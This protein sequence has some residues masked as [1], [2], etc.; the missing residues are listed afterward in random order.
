[1]QETSFI[2]VLQKIGLNYREALVYFTLIKSGTRGSIVKEL[3]HALPGEMKRTTVYSTL[4]KL[5]NMGI[6]KESGHADTSKNATIFIGT[7]PSKYFKSLIMSKEKEIELIKKSMEKNMQNLEKIYSDGIELKFDD[8]DE[9]IKPY[10]KPLMDNGWKVK[11]FIMR[12]DVP[13]LDY[14]VYDCMLYAPHANYLKDNSYHV[15]IFDYNIEKDKNALQFFI[16]RLKKKT[17]EMK[18]YF[19]DI[20]QFQF[21]DDSISLENREYPVF[22]MGAKLEELKKSEYFTQAKLGLKEIPDENKEN[23][24]EIG[25]TAIIPIRNKLFYIWAES[26]KIL[27]EMIL[28]ILEIED[29]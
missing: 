13:L 19:F 7:R 22:K 15:F 10:F 28:P 23:F 6:V 14:V 24:Y 8:L 29:I 9:F 12:R 11:S 17:R 3:I 25:K 27:K 18:S 2:E 26:N 1:M 20:K 4:R 5:I 21:F 16:N